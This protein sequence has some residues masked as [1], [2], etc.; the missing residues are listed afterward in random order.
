MTTRQ[1]AAWGA[2]ATG[3]ALA[4]ICIALTWVI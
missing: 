2:I 4:V 3:S 1:I